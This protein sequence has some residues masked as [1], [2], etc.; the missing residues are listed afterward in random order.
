VHHYKHDG[1]KDGSYKWGSQPANHKCSHVLCVCTEFLSILGG[2]DIPNRA[3][4]LEAAAHPME[5]NALLLLSSLLYF[6][7][8]I[9]GSIPI[10]DLF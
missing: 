4:L 1:N 8:F 3:Q 2:E 6:D 7:I 10:G 5:R 9:P